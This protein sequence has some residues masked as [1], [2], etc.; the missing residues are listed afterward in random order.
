MLLQQAE[1][2]SIPH[3]PE[4]ER[5]LVGALF[6]ADAAVWAECRLMVGKDD[7]FDARYGILFDVMAQFQ[8]SGQTID[9]PLIVAELRKR[10]LYEEFGG[11]SEIV[12]VLMNQPGPAAAKHYATVV[13]DRSLRRRLMQFGSFVYQRA[14]A[15]ADLTRD[16]DEIANDAAAAIGKL[17]VSNRRC[18][19][20]NIGA[21]LQNVRQQ[22]GGGG[23]P[24]VPTGFRELDLISG[25]VGIG[26]MMLIGAR[27]SMG[28]STLLRQIA[29]QCA[30]LGNPV[31]FISLE[32]STSKIGRNWLSSESGVENQKI[33]TGKLAEFEWDE[34]DSGISRLRDLPVYITDE[35][36]RMS[37]IRARATAWKARYGIKVLIIDYL[38]RIRGVQGNSRY[39]IASNISTDVSDML[40]EVGVAGIVAVQLNRAVDNRD[41]KRPGMSDIRESG[42]IEQDADGIVFLH[43]EDYYHLD[44]ADY[45]PDRI[46]EL[47]IAKWRDSVRGMVVKLRSNLSRQRFEDLDPSE[48]YGPD[49]DPAG[50]FN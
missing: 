9:A 23:V 5:G 45:Q 4:A 21:L 48:A 47:I 28:K 1:V 13:R 26:E 36:R 11:T 43:R 8:D 18:G 30:R 40:K 37:D 25:G 33:R 24:M 44:D 3:S 31:G 14:I 16:A 46:A 22:I 50:Y 49:N 19:D 41:D 38:Q 34:I 15:A 27:P 2:E 32:E 20:V 29:V 17:I 12:D 39:E 7:F 35:T 42:Q 6:F 10:K